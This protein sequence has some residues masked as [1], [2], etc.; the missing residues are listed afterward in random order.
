MRWKG[1]RIVRKPNQEL[2]YQTTFWCGLVLNELKVLGKKC[3]RAECK[4]AK[5]WGEK[6]KELS[7]G[8]TETQIV[9]R[10]ERNSH[11]RKLSM[12]MVWERYC[13]ASPKPELFLFLFVYIFIDIS[14][15]MRPFGVWVEIFTDDSPY[16]NKY[17][18]I[19]RSLC[20]FAQANTLTQ[21]LLEWNLA[22]WLF[23]KYFL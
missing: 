21:Y 10:F 23:Q 16:R 14:A 8:V 7:D 9:Q 18:T 20:S 13:N 3:R 22:Q 12:I 1:K 17:C 15:N 6:V 11:W 4:S 5:L 2:L 19:D